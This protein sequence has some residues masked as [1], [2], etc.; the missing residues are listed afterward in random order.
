MGIRLKRVF[1]RSEVE[2]FNEDLAREEEE[3]FK[4]MASALPGVPEDILRTAA[5]S[6]ARRVL[7]SPVPVHVAVESLHDQ[8]A[9]NFSERLVRQAVEEGW[10]SLS[11]GNLIIHTGDGD[12]D[13]VYKIE[14][15]PGV[16]CSHCGEKLDG[17]NE[18]AQAHI[19]DTHRDEE[20]P[21]PQNPS[22]YRV[23]N[24]YATTHVEGAPTAE[25]A[26][27][28]EEAVV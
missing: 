1:V 10:M 27:T 9:Q 19:T 6:M 11:R 20:S 8:G 22:G 16:Y 18:I 4:V 14:E 28:Q 5:A 26:V 2:A 25:G 21:D 15:A 17:G 24:H 12:E 3:Q 7:P 13:V 23:S